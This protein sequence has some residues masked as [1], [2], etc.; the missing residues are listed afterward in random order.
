M[1]AAK[2]VRAQYTQ[3]FKL[4]AVRQVSAGQ[5]IAVVAKVL[6]IPKASLGN[7]VRQAAKGALSGAGG[8]NKAVGVSPEQME[9]ARLRAEVARLRME[10]DIA[11]SRGVLC[12]GQAARYAWIHQ[13]RQQYPVSASCGVLEVSANGYFNWLRRPQDMAGMP[14]GRHSD[15]ALLAH[16]R[17]IHTEVKGE[18]GWPR[19]HKELL[20]RG[21]RVGKDRVRK[22][23]QQHGIRA[24]TKRKFVVT[25]DSRHSLPVT[26][27][28]VQ[29]RFTP[30][31]PNQ[32]WSGDITYIATD[33]GWLYLAAVIDLFSRQVVGWSLQPHMQAGLVKDA[34]AMAWWRRRPPTGL[35]FHSDR[36]SQYC[37]GEFQD[38]LKDWKMR[39]SMS[40]KGNCW[41]NAPTESFW[42]RLKTASVHGHKF[43]TR[44]QAKQAVM[45][46]MAFYNHRRLH[47]SLGYLSPMQFEQRWYEAQR[48]K[49]A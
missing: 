9:I 13:M 21:I 14:G 39:S 30:E 20:A 19:M 1:T 29:R 16:I 22:L 6:G 8:D 35:I 47:S 27:D 7:W 43:A 46:W 17:A 28:L 2:Q 34:L 5:A 41:D 33:E 36:G 23:M 48:K 37:S 11:K 10:R 26:L 15:E 49:A 3:E 4:E 45:D 38:A 32:L 40:R 31:A 24:R 42:G 25:T 18:Y 12:A 44:E